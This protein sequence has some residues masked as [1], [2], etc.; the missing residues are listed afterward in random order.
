MHARGLQGSLDFG[1]A[2]YA[3]KGGTRANDLFLLS[4]RASHAYG[5]YAQMVYNHISEAHAL[6]YVRNRIP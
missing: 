6:F 3:V 1:A 4:T 5:S 2:D